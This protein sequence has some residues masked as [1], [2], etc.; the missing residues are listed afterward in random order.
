[1]IAFAMVPV[2]VGRDIDDRVMR[3]GFAVVANVLV[4]AR[5]LDDDAAGV[6]RRAYAAPGRTSAATSGA[7]TGVVR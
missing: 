4:G 6:V 3:V 1:M 7:P 2:T 5:D